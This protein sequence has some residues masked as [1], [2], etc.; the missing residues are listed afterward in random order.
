VQI[1]KQSQLKENGSPP[2]AKLA[3]QE[4]IRMNFISRHVIFPTRENGVSTSEASWLRFEKKIACG[5][6]SA[7]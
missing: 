2:F 5:P 3:E 7:L 4:K 6:F 1:Q